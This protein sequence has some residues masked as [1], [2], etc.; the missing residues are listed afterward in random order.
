MDLRVT[1][2]NRVVPLVDGW[3]VP[4]KIW[5]DLYDHTDRDFPSWFRVN[6]QWIHLEEFSRI[7]TREQQAI[8]LDHHAIT[9]EGDS[10]LAKWDGLEMDA[11]EGLV[12]RFSE[13]GEG[14]VIG[15]C[16]RRAAS[17]L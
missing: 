10:P 11:V 14:V 17:L 16:H 3:H 9:V 7:A 12:V 4:D 5:W 1:T 13:D 2:N 8:S 15:H 6:R